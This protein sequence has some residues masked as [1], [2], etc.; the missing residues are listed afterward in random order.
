MVLSYAEDRKC[1]AYMIKDDENKSIVKCGEKS[2]ISGGL[3]KNHKKLYSKIKYINVGV[4]LLYTSKKKM[5]L[6]RKNDTEQKLFKHIILEIVENNY[7]FNYTAH[8]YEKEL[9]NIEK[10]VFIPQSDWQSKTSNDV[11][12]DSLF[13]TTALPDV[14]KITFSPE[15][16]NFHPETRIPNTIKH[17]SSGKV[18]I[19]NVIN[20]ENIETIEITADNKSENTAQECKLIITNAN[21]LKKISISSA[22]IEDMK[23]ENCK[24]LK[25]VLILNSSFINKFEMS[26]CEKVDTL[27]MCNG[28]M[29]KPFYT[30]IATATSINIRGCKFKNIKIYGYRYFI[31]QLE[32][33]DCV[34]KN[35]FEIT[36]TCIVE[37]FNVTDCT[38]EELTLAENH[39][40]S[41]YND[42]DF[43]EICVKNSN[44]Q[45][46]KVNDNTKKIKRL[47]LS[48][49]NVEENFEITDTDFTEGIQVHK[50]KMSFA[51]RFLLTPTLPTLTRK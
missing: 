8:L 23:I 16:D 49:C 20:K 31:A 42:I 7:I 17:I 2:G 35:G 12:C 5:Y 47:T 32:L 13:F 21:N 30:D 33:K 38:I 43:G 28:D 1:L 34:V 50:C 37:Y 18:H 22:S 19:A 45:S 4:K 6:G 44:F 48:N 40:Y 14:V 36:K 25:E 10:Y 9:H 51:G 26:G 39:T 11:E 3:C 41:S 27:S 24:N 46:I 29:R 15:F